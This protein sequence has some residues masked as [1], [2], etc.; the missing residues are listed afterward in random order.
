MPIHFHE[1]LLDCPSPTSISRNEMDT[2][3]IFI[4]HQDL[5]SVLR[6]GHIVEEDPPTAKIIRRLRHVRI[7][8]ELSRGEFLDICY[9]KSPRSIRRCERNSARC[10]EETSRTVFSTRSEGRKIEL[11]TALDGVSIPTAS[12]ILTL[13]NPKN[14]G[15]IDIRVWKL[16]H[17]LGSVKSNPRGQGFTFQHWYHYLQILRYHARLLGVSV[18]LV[19]LTLFRYHQRHQTGNLYDR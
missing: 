19:E 6:K 1:C 9:W 18:R 8:K 14:Y 7:D 12:A 16:L 5:G 15:V 11:L 10:I 3:S 17:D 2:D 4:R 13:T